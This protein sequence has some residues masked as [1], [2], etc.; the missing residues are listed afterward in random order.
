[1]VVVSQEWEFIFNYDYVPTFVHLLIAEFKMT[2]SCLKCNISSRSSGATWWLTV[3]TFIHLVQFTSQSLLTCLFKLSM[4]LL[5]PQLI[6]NLE[7]IS[8]F[9]GCSFYHTIP[10]SNLGLEVTKPWDSS[11]SISRTSQWFGKNIGRCQNFDQFQSAIVKG[12]CVPNMSYKISQFCFR[13]QYLSYHQLNELIK[14][15]FW[16]HK[17]K[18]SE[19][20]YAFFVICKSVSHPMK[21][22]DKERPPRAKEIEVKNM[23]MF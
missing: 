5:Q 20:T 14:V 8:I 12:H 11:K 7:N 3:S 17:M 9:Q 16:Y 4:P 1:M 2:M 21:V 23:S 13:Y 18:Q 19:H 15:S 6:G 10:Q 22:S